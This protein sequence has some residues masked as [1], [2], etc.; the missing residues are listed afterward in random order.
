MLLSAATMWDAKEKILVDSEEE[1]SEH[2][3][4]PYV[5]PTKRSF[6]VWSVVLPDRVK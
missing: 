3:G 2:L 4:L 5:P 1:L 6:A